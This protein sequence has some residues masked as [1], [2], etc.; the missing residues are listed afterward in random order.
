MPFDVIQDDKTLP[1]EEVAAGSAGVI[2][3]VEYLGVVL[4][5]TTLPTAVVV[6]MIILALELGETL[7]CPFHTQHQFLF[8]RKKL[9]L[10]FG[11]NNHTPMAMYNSSTLNNKFDEYGDKINSVP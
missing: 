2:I 9:N 1:V 4:A 10:M 11:F 6:L 5:E 8:K 7:L 3:V